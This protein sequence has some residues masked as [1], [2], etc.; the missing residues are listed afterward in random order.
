[1]PSALLPRLEDK[2]ILPRFCRTP[3]NVSACGPPWFLIS[4]QGFP[5]TTFRDPQT[6]PWVIPDQ[7]ETPMGSP[8]SINCEKFSCSFFAF[9]FFMKHCQ[10]ARSLL[11]A[12]QSVPPQS[13]PL[14]E[15]LIFLVRAFLPEIP[16]PWRIPM[17]FPPIG[18]PLT[19][20]PPFFF[21]FL[22]G[23]TNLW[24]GPWADCVCPLSFPLRLSLL[25]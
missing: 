17:P 23:C 2:N 3:H 4:W 21:R 19:K 20:G 16:L 5:S 1:M 9:D 7:P 24:P 15:T 6:S 10:E 13:Q 22:D 25:F 11:L 18:F 14:F 12:P 8:A